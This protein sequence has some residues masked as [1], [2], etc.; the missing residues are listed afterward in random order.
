[1][2]V[3]INVQTHFKNDGGGTHGSAVKRL[4]VP[5][6]FT[7]MKRSFATWPARRNV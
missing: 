4:A 3:K 1:M 7:A 2:H 6:G 5:I